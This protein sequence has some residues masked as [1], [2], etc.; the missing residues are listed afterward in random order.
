MRLFLNALLAGVACLSVSCNKDRENPTITVSEPGDGVEYHWGDQ[1][2][3]EAMFEDNEE[4]KS[5]H[6]FIGNAS[7]D[8]DADLN[9]SFSQTIDGPVYEFHEHANVPDS[10]DGEYFVHFEA[11]DEE[12]NSMTTKRRIVFVE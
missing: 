8:V 1:V 6:V 2:H 10:A 9:V 4:L 7:G 3:L 5:I 12:E 11:V